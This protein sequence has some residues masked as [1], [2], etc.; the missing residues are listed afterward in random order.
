MWTRCVHRRR[1]WWT[2][3]GHIFIFM[4]YKI[5]ICAIAWSGVM[6]FSVSVIYGDC[7][8]LYRAVWIIILPGNMH[9]LFS[10][11]R[12]ASWMAKL[13]IA[14]LCKSTYQIWRS[15]WFV[16]YSW[17]LSQDSWIRRVWLTFILV[18]MRM[19]ILWILVQHTGL[20]RWAC[21]ILSVTVLV[22][23]HKPRM[24]YRTWFT[25]GHVKL[26][27]IIW[28]VQNPHFWTWCMRRQLLSTK[29]TSVSSI[30]MWICR[31]QMCPSW[32]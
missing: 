21:T 24:Q 22:D 20:L 2:G 14:T 5:C 23:I 3:I 15:P 32:W 19:Y 1:A 16:K 18:V 6:I 9:I 17:A 26:T 27:S 4:W 31:I 13:F 30:I 8:R 7:F 29:I 10:I 25:L 12:R 28:M 11:M